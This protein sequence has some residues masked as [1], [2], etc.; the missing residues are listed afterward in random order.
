MVKAYTKNLYG[1]KTPVEL[2]GTYKGK[3]YCLLDHSDFTVKESAEELKERLKS[4]FSFIKPDNT[5][6]WYDDQ[7]FT[8]EINFKKL[9]EVV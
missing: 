5:I 4:G 2:S 9:K 3:G 1:K 7:P 6:R 8:I